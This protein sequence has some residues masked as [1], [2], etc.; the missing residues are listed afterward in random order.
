MNRLLVT[1]VAAGIYGAVLAQPDRAAIDLEQQLRRQIAELQAEGGPTPAG[2][3]EPLRA[4]ALLYEENG[5][6][7]LAIA[8][9]EEAR[10]VTRV[11]EG[12]SSADEA[13]LLRQQIRTEKALGNDD[14][15]WSLEQDMVTIA[16]QNHDDIRMAA[17]FRELA[18]DRA[19]ALEEYGGGGFPPE[20]E[21]GCYY[22]PGFRRYDDT[23]G[24][25]RS[26]PPGQDGSCFSGQSMYVTRRLRAETLMYYAD[27]IEVIIKNG[28]YASHEL[29]DLERRAFRASPFPAS[30]DPV[31][32]KK[33]D[34]VPVPGSRPISAPSAAVSSCSMAR[35]QFETL[36]EL[37]SSEIPGSCLA[38]VLHTERIV[39]ANVGGWVS[40]VRLIAY[41]IRSGA[42]ADE[43]A[44]AFTDL[45]DWYLLQTSVGG[46]SREDSNDQAIDIYERAYREL[47]QNDAARASMFFP[48]VP[49]TFAP[50]PFASIST[51]EPSR[52]IDVSF[53]VTKYGRGEHIEI[54]GTSKSA[55]R[56]EERELI[57]LIESTR[58]RP[59][60][61]DGTLAA[62][63][64]VI[65]RY[66]LGQ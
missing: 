64:P 28:D 7:L 65:A 26:P 53:D 33:G 22:V 50:N 2:L 38:P 30:A 52:Y 49:V 41:E 21:L 14:R 24:V 56:A 55:T 40:L 18:E 46:R 54:L 17:V 43:R 9:L 11:H 20:I 44:N 27:A 36:A 37:L 6:Q 3:V 32:Q 4:L 15:V 59:R 23:R 19:D 61:V 10:H 39:E 47:E 66:P 60:F 48:A 34:W 45:A 31:L 25:E 42:A 35:A 16:R 1:T 8:A 12:L 63:A 58:F 57:L 62:A 51:A 5:D 29:R 13:L